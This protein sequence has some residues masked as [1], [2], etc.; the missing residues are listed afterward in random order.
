MQLVEV[1]RTLTCSVKLT[2][3]VYGASVLY[4]FYIAR[5]N[6]L[7]IFICNFIMALSHALTTYHSVGILFS[8]QNLT[9]INS[10]V[11]E[12]AFMLQQNP[13]Q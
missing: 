3:N 11:T 2:D 9:V 8:H 4:L 10:D 12:D 5:E 1:I 7:K 6:T 13:E